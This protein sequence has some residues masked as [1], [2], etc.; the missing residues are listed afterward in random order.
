MASVER[1]SGTDLTTTRLT[2]K[3]K[4]GQLAVRY[5]PNILRGTATRWAETMVNAIPVEYPPNFD[6]EY[7]QAIED[8]CIPIFITNHSSDYDGLPAAKVTDKLL[9]LADGAMPWGK[10][11]EG[12]LMITAN[13]LQKGHAVE[14][15]PGEVMMFDT[16]G[17]P[18]LSDRGITPIFTTTKNDRKRGGI[19]LAKN[20]NQF[21]TEL[22]EKIKTGKFG[23]FLFPE[24]SVNSGRLDK[25]GKRKGM[26]E[27]ATGAVANYITK[28][29]EL[30]GRDVVV[31]SAAI[32]G[33][34]KVYDHQT[35]RPSSKILKGFWHG[36]SEVVKVIVNKPIRSMNN[37]IAGFRADASV[38]E[39]IGIDGFFGRLIARLL[40]PEEQGNVYRAS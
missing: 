19:G 13:S 9:S 37:L 12:F 38:R 14:L 27:F 28:I 30:T 21:D 34:Y 35:S 4:L 25:N 36:D 20:S 5:G 16:L 11:L 29:K 6:T 33:S 39:K 8:G 22:E 18:F 23:I 15:R 24:A 40:P 1:T 17:R 2:N 31:I 26:Q 32:A 10:G 7:R 3:Q